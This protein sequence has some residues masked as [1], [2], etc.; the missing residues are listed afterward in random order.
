MTPGFSFL[1]SLPP[2]WPVFAKHPE[3]GRRADR[4]SLGFTDALVVKH[5]KSDGWY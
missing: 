4:A 2:L 5:A 3:V 1:L